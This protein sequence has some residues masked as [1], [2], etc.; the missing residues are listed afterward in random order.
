MRKSATCQLQRTHLVHGLQ[1][2]VCEVGS[3]LRAP[4]HIVCARLLPGQLCAHRNVVLPAVQIANR[5]DGRPKVLQS[6]SLPMHVQSAASMG[7]TGIE[8]EGDTSLLQG[9]LFTSGW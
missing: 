5:T 7:T 9:G 2:G 6:C 3:E 8:G 1:L 4:V